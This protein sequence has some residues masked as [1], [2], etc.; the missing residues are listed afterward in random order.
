MFIRR[1]NE[2]GHA[3]HG[4]LDTHHTFSF[5]RY[6]DPRFMGFS[7]L[8]VINEDRVQ[9]GRGFGK[10]PH[11]NME[12]I[13]YVLE[14][15]LEHRDSTGSG[16]VIRPGEVQLMS[17]GSGVTHSEFNA[18][19][20]E[21]V[22]FLQIWILPA[23]EDTEPRWAHLEFDWESRTNQFR[24]LVTPDGR[25]DT[26]EIGQ[27]AELYNTRLEDGA[28]TTYTMPA[29]RKT[30]VQMARG[31]ATVNGIELH[32]GDGVAFVEPG[33]LEFEGS[34]GAEILLFNLADRGRR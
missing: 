9:P 6:Y 1:S 7:D 18:S 17:A 16:G 14:G 25:D 13:S 28:T 4:W 24:P 10:H 26:L 21:P 19:D 33:D 20:T 29:G 2:R 22:H 34:D 12:I 30:W 27:D 32:A 8:R 15:G 31:T 3:N 5:A 23:A 11:S